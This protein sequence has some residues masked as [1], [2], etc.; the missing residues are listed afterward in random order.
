MLPSQRAW[1]REATPPENSSVLR[2]EDQYPTNAT[3]GHS[4]CPGSARRT[5][6]LLDRAEKDR[7][8]GLRPRRWQRLRALTTSTPSW[9]GSLPGPRSTPSFST[10]AHSST[11]STAR[12][13]FGLN[14]A[15]VTHVRFG[16]LA[17]IRQRIG[18]LRFIP[19][20]RHAHLRHRCPLSA[21][22]SLKS[23]TAQPGTISVSTL[24]YRI[25]RHPIDRAQ[26]ARSHLRKTSCNI[27]L[28]C[29]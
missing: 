4:D 17:D 2:R 6:F 11:Q 21:I 19:R 9:P 12:R 28:Y 1:A 22:S 20:S 3:G 15:A 24:K 8:L 5:H 7:N 29:L 23:L 13:C 14:K 27:L 26:G 25:L 10:I 16:S 18:D